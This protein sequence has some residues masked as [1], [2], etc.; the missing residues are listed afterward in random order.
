MG[1]VGTA[2]QGSTRRVDVCP[3]KVV[4]VRILKIV[5]LIRLF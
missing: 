5:D 3:R 2:A 4:N 1:D